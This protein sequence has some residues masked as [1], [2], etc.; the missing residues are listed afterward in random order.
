M[1]RH[2]TIGVR[3]AIVCAA[4]GPGALNAQ[5]GS[6]VG[7]VY[8]SIDSGPLVDAAVFLWSTPFRGVTDEEGRYQIEGVPVGS[9][10]V[11]FFHPRLAELGVS[12]GTQPVTV[13]E[14][15][16]A[17]VHLATPSLATIVTSQCLVEERPARAGS[18]AGRVIDGESG[19]PLGGSYVSFSWNV[20]NSPLPEGFTLRTDSDGRFRSCRLPADTPVLLSAVYIGRQ[21]ERYEIVLGENDFSEAVLPLV[22]MS[23]GQI[24]GRL[25]DATSAAPVEGAETWLRGTAFRT[26]SGRD[27]SFTFRDVPPGRY[28]LVA[29]HLAY[30]TRMDTLAVPDGQRLLVEMKVDSRA[31]AMAPLDVTVEPVRD[32]LGRARGGLMISSEQID[33][34]RQRSRDASDVLRSLHIPGVIVRHNSNGTICVGY[35]TGQVKMY[36]TG[37]VEMMI[38]IND[39]RAT[40]ADLALRLP[41]DGIERMVLYKPVEAGNLFGL[42]AGNGV[43]MIYTRG[44]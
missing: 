30:G 24:A 6:V 32:I 34:V 39:V 14:G 7:T 25:T 11:L 31:I 27:G 1:G 42:G 36:Q 13:G 12:V 5:T 26:L 40:D 38:Y 4:I 37:C 2:V 3:I 16:P 44:N 43:W 19:I 33:E 22:E 8:D 28:M 10:E 15:L 35:S 29:D 17:E 20:P 23:P 21:F 18:L 9:Y 41:P